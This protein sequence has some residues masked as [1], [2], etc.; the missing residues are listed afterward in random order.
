[1]SKTDYYELL[2][3]SRNVDAQGLKKAFRKKAMECHPDRNPDNAEAEQKFKELNEAYEV[4]KDPQKRRA[5]DQYGHA[6]FE[7]GGGGFHHDF[8]SSMADIFDDIF[9]EFMGGG[10]R[11]N[12]SACQRGSDLRYNLQ[13]TLE[14]AFNGKSVEIELPTQV[15]C[16]SCS[17]TGAKSGT[18]PVSC[19]TCQGIGKVRAQQGF[20]MIERTCPTC[21]GRGEIIKDPCSVCHGAG[22]VSKTRTLSVS[23]PAGIEDGT[24]IRLA[25]EGEAGLRGNANGDL[26][27]FVS[28]QEH[29]FFKRDGAD[30]YCRVPVSMA[31]AT[32]GHSIEVPTLDGKE[33]RIKIP[34]GTQNGKQFRL[35]GKGMPII[36][37]ERVGDLYVQVMVETPRN[38]T[39]KQREL[40]EEFAAI[41]SEETQPETTSFFEKVKG[42]IDGV[43]T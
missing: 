25:G 38:L 39:K 5:Y 40:L 21:H 6:A 34:E 7:Q 2:D 8:G 24:R 4:L 18:K 17:G 28:V 42:F 22:R 20:F 9:G 16:D 31:H 41:S 3:V 27:I 36:R 14:E 43:T 23:I 30:L 37:S 33:S 19:P 11:R 1:M 15:T 35:K 26:Y 13:I 32:L 10:R 12:A 29:L